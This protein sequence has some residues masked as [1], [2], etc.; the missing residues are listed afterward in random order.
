MNTVP[1]R[2]LP[3]RD[4]VLVVLEEPPAPSAL[5]TVVRLERQPT[6]LA[7][8]HAIGPEVRETHVGQRVIVSRLQGIEVGTEV[9][10]PESA[11]LAHLVDDV[12]A[13]GAA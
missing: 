9:L 5:V 6:T 7:R 10:L 13:D 8:V 4:L 11:V 12:Q 1:L 3:L 2:V